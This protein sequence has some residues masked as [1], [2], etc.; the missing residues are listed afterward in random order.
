MVTLRSRS[1]FAGAAK[2]GIFVFAGRVPEDEMENGFRTMQDLLRSLSEAGKGLDKGTS[3]LDALEQACTDARELFERL[4]V[5]RHKARESAIGKADRNVGVHKENKLKIPAEAPV[6][7]K[8]DTRPPDVSPRQTSLIDAIETV[9]EKPVEKKETV[10]AAERSSSDDDPKP[11]AA[12]SK[13]SQKPATLAEKL[14][15]ASITSLVRSIS[16]S[17]KFW[18]VSELYNGDRIGY[19]KGIEKIDSMSERAEAE[20]YFQDEVIAKLKKPADPAAL[21]AFMD[22][23]DRRFQ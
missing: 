13:A 4:V 14:E 10:S 22:L 12:R 23:L 18:F 19:E 8:L 1:G 2:I 16:L 9:Q 6:P 3:D 5:L 15:K 11:A 21:A 20:S 17:H 7:I